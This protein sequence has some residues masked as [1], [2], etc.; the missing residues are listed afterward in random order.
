MTEPLFAKLRE[1]YKEANPHGISVW[2]SDAE[3]NKDAIL[4]VATFNALPKL[5]SAL[6]LME[7]ALGFYATPWG[8]H[9]NSGDPDTDELIRNRLDSVGLKARDTLAEVREMGK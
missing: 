6:D 7:E 3:L 1:L 8:K 4:I 5:F 9:H 2:S